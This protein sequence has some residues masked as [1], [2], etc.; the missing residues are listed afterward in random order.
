VLKIVNGPDLDAYEVQDPNKYEETDQEIA[1]LD[2][3]DYS[4]VEYEM[5]KC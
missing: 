1:P 4:S 2:E 5:L 3:V